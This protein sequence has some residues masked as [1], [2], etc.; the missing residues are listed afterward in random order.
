L[1]SVGKVVVSRGEEVERSSG[2]GLNGTSVEQAGGLVQVL[3]VLGIL[4]VVTSELRVGLAASGLSSRRANGGLVQLAE[5]VSESLGEHLH[6]GDEIVVVVARHRTLLQRNH[7]GTIS[8]VETLSGLTLLV[9][10]RSGPLEVDVIRLRDLEVVGGEVILGGGVALHDVSTT[11]TDSQVV[12]AGTNWDVRGAGSNEERVRTILEGTSI[13]V[14][15]N[16]EGQVTELLLSVNSVGDGGVTSD[17]GVL[18][19]EGGVDHVSLLVINLSESVVVSR[20]DVVANAEN[21]GG[22]L[23]AGIVGHR[24]DDPL[25]GGGHDCTRDVDVTQVVVTRVLGGEALWS[26]QTP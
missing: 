22:E 19:V 17:W 4:L 25:V 21:A 11:T 14:G 3:A 1:R 15:V 20:G 16:G 26:G 5:T 9:E 23:L 24:R 7:V 13:L 18:S 6:V 10:V 2:R 8:L 12:Y